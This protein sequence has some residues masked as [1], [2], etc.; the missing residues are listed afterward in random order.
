M[1]ARIDITNA[2]PIPKSR[3]SNSLEVNEKPNLYNFSK[4][5]PNIIGI[6]KKNENSAATN[7]LVP[8]TI[9]PR[10]VAPE[11]DVPGINDKT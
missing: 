4:L 11:R 5:A 9:A 3:I 6:D 1:I 7:R 8:S 10:I 2:V